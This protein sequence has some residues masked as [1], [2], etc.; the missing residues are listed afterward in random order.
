M[1][2]RNRT[3][4]KVEQLEA[5]D[6]PST[7]PLGCSDRAQVT[8]TTDLLVSGAPALVTPDPGQ[9]VTPGPALELKSVNAG[10]VGPAAGL[11]TA[12]FPPCPEKVK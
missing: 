10:P 2:I 6:T 4:L 11:D 8:Y 1:A 9:I 12:A 5:R 7:A 3:M